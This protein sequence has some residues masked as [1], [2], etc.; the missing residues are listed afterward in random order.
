MII[1]L[2]DYIIIVKSKS[3]KFGI[4]SKNILCSF[5]FL[6]HFKKINEFF[7]QRLIIALLKVNKNNRI[8]N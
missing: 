3:Q 6:N 5:Y 2:L 8:V 1:R 4:F 7:F